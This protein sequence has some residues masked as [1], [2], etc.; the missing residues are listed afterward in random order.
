MGQSLSER[1]IVGL[2]I[3]IW[4]ALITL[5]LRSYQSA[6]PALWSYPLMLCEAVGMV[7][8]A[9]RRLLS[10]S[11]WCLAVAVLAVAVLAVAVLAVA[12]ALPQLWDSPGTHG[13]LRTLSTIDASQS[14]ALN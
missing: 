11:P 14:L 8:A 5:F 7:A 10:R 2:W 6:R 13:T 1:S 9:I 4:A 12:V 3:L